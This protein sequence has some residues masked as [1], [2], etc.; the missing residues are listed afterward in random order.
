MRV[1]IDATSVLLRSAGVKSYTYHWIEHLRRL[2]RSEI[3]AFPFL[4]RFGDLT[5]EGSVVSPLA[6][7]PRLALLY[8]VNIPGNPAMDWLTSGVDV[9]HVSNQVRQPP[10]KTRLTATIFD[11]TC[12][13]V[14][15]FHTP[16]NIKADQSFTEQVLT[17]ADSLIAI[18]ENSKADAVRLL[19]VNPERIE[20]IH[21][22]I[23]EQ[24]FGAAASPRSKPYVLYVGAI[25]PRKNVDRLLDAWHLLKPSLREEFDLV[26]AGAT[27]WQSERTVRRLEAGIRDI[28]YLRYV[29]EQELPGL[30]AGATA[31]VYPSLYEGFGFPVAQAMACGVPV[32]TSNNSC[33]PEIV[34]PGGLFVDPRSPIEIA[35]ALERLLT[36]PGVRD[37]L[38]A[39]GAV[40]AHRYRWEICAQKSL[41]FFRRV[42]G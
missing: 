39:A 23:P 24:Y 13:I 5:H 29:P 20:V 1:L 17:R 38:G 30:T 11:L 32:I 27:G 16:G 12:R 42:C 36:S 18:S 9:F 4:D 41:E 21:P 19:G 33:L 22:G 15:E 10:K 3:Q 7:Y 2:A 6:T 14:P 40:H 8:F 34:G 28:R 26:V 31:F 37:R 35:A 25:E